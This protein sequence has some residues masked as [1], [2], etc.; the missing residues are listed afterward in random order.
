MK[1]I[2]YDVETKKQKKK[3]HIYYHDIVQYVVI[4]SVYLNEQ[5]QHVNYG[6]VTDL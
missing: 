2:W 6:T 3:K 1:K 5:V 4:S